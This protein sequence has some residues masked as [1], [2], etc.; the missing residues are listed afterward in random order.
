MGSEVFGP[1]FTTTNFPRYRVCNEKSRMIKIFILIKI[2][3]KKCKRPIVFVSAPMELTRTFPENLAV[4][5]LK[6][7]GLK[8][9]YLPAPQ[10]SLGHCLGASLTNPMLITAYRYLFNPLVIRSFVMR[11]GP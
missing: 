7:Y 5:V 6:G 9:Y 11:L 4:T 10:P 3:L 1:E 2:F 8:L